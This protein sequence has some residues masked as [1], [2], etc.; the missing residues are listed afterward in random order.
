MPL[1]IFPLLRPPLLT[2][3]FFIVVLYFLLITIVLFEVSYIM[4]ELY[5]LLKG[6]NI[7]DTLFI[8]FY[9]VPS[10]LAD[11]YSILLIL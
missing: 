1:I 6:M 8:F 3:I 7:R 10:I 2:L 4:G 11:F 9:S 5:N